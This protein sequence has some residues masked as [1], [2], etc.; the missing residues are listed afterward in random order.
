MP[1]L[2]GVQTYAMNEQSVRLAQRGCRW[3]YQLCPTGEVALA[4]FYESS[5]SKDIL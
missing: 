4:N 2:L 1:A 5:G 3:R